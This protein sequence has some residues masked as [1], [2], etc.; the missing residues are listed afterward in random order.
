MKGSFKYIIGIACSL[1]A[2]YSCA[3]VEEQELQEMEKVEMVRMEFSADITDGAQTK[4]VLGGEMGDEYRQILWQPEDS[5]GICGSWWWY[6]GMNKFVNAEVEDASTGTFVG[7]ISEESLYYAFYPHNPNL[8]YYEYKYIRFTQPALQKYHPESFNRNAMPMVAKA[9]KGETMHFQSLCGVLALNLTGSETIK[10]VSFTGYDVSGNSL[11]VAGKFRVAMD[12]ESYPQMEVD[13]YDD[14]SGQT[15]S[16]VTLDCEDGVVLNPSEP[17]PFYIV[18]PVETYN[19][20]II[21]VG[22][23]DGKIMALNGTNPLEIKRANVTKTGSC[24]FVAELTYNLS[25][26]GTANCYIVTEPGIYT[27]NATIIGNGA[28]GFED[29]DV[30]TDTPFIKPVSADMLWEDHNGMITSVVF[31]GENVSFLATGTEGN[32]LIAVRDESGTILWSWH[33]WVTDQPDIEVYVNSTGEYAM[34][35]RNL[36][37]IRDDRGTGN[38]WY[39]AEGLRYQWGRKDPMAL[40]RLNSGNFNK[41]YSTYS[42]TVT[43]HASVQQPNSFYGAGYSYWNYEYNETLWS[44]DH[45]TIYD[46]CPVGY[47]VPSMDPW[48]SFTVNELT[49]WVSM[50]FWNMYGPYNNGVDFIYD[51]TNHTYYPATDLINAEG[52]RESDQGERAYMWTA[53]SM[54][55]DGAR[56]FLFNYYPSYG[57]SCVHNGVSEQKSHAF[58]VRCMKDEDNEKY[59]HPLVNM[60]SITD[61]SSEEATVTAS[62][63]ASGTSAVTDR[64]FVWGTDSDVTL[65]NASYMSMGSGLGVFSGTITGLRNSTKYFVRAYAVND[66]GVAYSGVCEF[67]TAGEGNVFNLSF[68]GTA[69]CYIVPPVSRSYVFDASVKGNSTE[70]VGEIASVEVLWETVMTPSTLMK[71]KVISEVAL[72]GNIVTLTLPAEP[73][74]G[75]ALVAVKDINGTI[76]WSWHIWVVDFEP[77]AT[78]VK[79]YSGATVMDRNLGAIS[80]ESGTLGSFGFLYQWGRK[81]PFVVP[82]DRYTEPYRAATAPADVFQYEYRD[83]YGDTVER[84]IQNPCVVYDDARWGY[85]SNLWAVQKTMYDPCPH[86]WK[87]AESGIWDNLYRD[88]NAQW[89]YFKVASKYAKPSLCIQAPGYTTGDDYLQ[90]S[91]QAGYLWT[92]SQGQYV[93]AWVWNDMIYV[94]SKDSDCLL[95]V[96]CMK[97]TEADKDASGDDYTVDDEYIWN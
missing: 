54:S 41:L 89:W 15:I 35:D 74:E 57:S 92:S 83:P 88:T 13:L 87:V 3:R 38:E 58:S 63:T 32:A 60:I 94:D 67:Y 90:N 34:Q 19:T 72:N 16:S 75:N 68:E 82:G 91:G 10:S 76:L 73:K 29:V 43:V 14:A 97:D 33:I 52:N 31:D 84:S 39:D 81:D 24:A 42:S 11:P 65:E 12:Y 59:L 22:T 69:N 96:R 79:L 66:S 71:G 28:Y 40:Q 21:T 37:A 55:S 20:F 8:Y 48:R 46:P 45:K 7:D 70:S 49:D 61:E 86:G 53:E 4:T 2:V 51:G 93:Q 26:E 44:V 18:L 27:F 9:N 62:I 30:H 78:Q 56:C 36:G 85:D 77:E 64:G 47:R 6:S 5:I 80:L 95:G 1:A 17:T 23:T 25:Q 50:E